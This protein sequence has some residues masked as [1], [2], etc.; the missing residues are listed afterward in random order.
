[1]PHKFIAPSLCLSLSFSPSFF[2]ILC[3]RRSLSR[4]ASAL[5]VR[6]PGL[7]QVLNFYG[8]DHSEFS[9]PRIA[10]HPSG[11]YFYCTS[12]DR[13]IQAYAVATRSV[14][15][16]LEGHTGT[17]RDLCYDRSRDCLWS[18][19]YDQSVREWTFDDSLLPTEAADAAMA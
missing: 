5:T 7:G 12:G 13:L 17:V 11:R 18:C 8:M 4:S 6:G 2:L 1:M 9:Q 16:K 3:A 14:V 15:Y 19:A 10:W